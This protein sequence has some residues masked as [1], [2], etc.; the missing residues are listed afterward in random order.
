M[1]LRPTLI[2][3]CKAGTVSEL[4][5]PVKICAAGKTGRPGLL[6]L[7]AAEIGNFCEAENRTPQNCRNLVQNHASERWGMGLEAQATS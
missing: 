3:P 7:R 5:D 2:A 6:P 4:A 1:R